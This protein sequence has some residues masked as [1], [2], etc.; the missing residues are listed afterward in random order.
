L[1]RSNWKKR[2]CEDW[3][4]GVPEI[5]EVWIGSGDLH[6]SPRVLKPIRAYFEPG[7]PKTSDPDPNMTGLFRGFFD[8][9]SRII[10]IIAS[11]ALDMVFA[12]FKTGLFK[13]VWTE[14]LP[15]GRP[16]VGGHG[17]PLF[18]LEVRVCPP[19]LYGKNPCF[20]HA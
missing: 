5:P 7:F 15:A 11:F 19:S 2:S 4:T 10:V 20:D 14:D 13:P 18:F 3:I 9:I 16:R 8:S 1:Q 6:R 12:R 17:K